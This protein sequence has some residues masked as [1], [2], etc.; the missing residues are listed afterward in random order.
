M[1]ND[2]SC[3]SDST[4]WCE[5]LFTV[6]VYPLLITASSQRDPQAYLPLP[7]PKNPIH[8]C[9]LHAAPHPSIRISIHPSI[10]S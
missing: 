7:A 5:L 1:Q 3:Q 4:I 2:V 10:Y 6:P 8:P 9:I